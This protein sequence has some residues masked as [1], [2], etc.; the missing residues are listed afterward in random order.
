VSF[1][2]PWQPGDALPRPE[3][4]LPHRAPFLLVDEITEIVPNQR[5]RGRWTPPADL[6]FFAGH[7]PGYPVVPGVLL[8][9]SLAQMGA[10]GAL[11]AEGLEGDIPFFGGIDKA[12]FRRQVRPGETI[13]LEVEITRRSKRAGKGT[14]RATVDGELA[15]ETGLF[16]LVVNRADLPGL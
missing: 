7:F 4:L 16:F 3:D 12:R 5:A 6:P 15:C 10:V 8:I 2:G 14:G 13:D 1:E 9:E 11:A